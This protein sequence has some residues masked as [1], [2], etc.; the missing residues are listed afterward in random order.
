MSRIIAFPL[1][2]QTGGV[3][4]EVTTLAAR[5]HRIEQS[6]SD[7]EAIMGLVV[8]AESAALD[9]LAA[10]PALSYDDAAV[11]L[12]TLLRR[13]ERDDDGFLPA[14]EVALLRSAL[15]DLRRLGRS[16]CA[17]QA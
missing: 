10:A 4:A 8:D 12:A 14:G 6:E 9:A 11:K 7:D 16:I 15:G 5:L 13:V 17:A 3:Q 1:A 2:R